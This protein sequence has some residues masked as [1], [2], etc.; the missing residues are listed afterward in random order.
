[1]RALLFLR[2]LLRD[3]WVRGTSL[4]LHLE[5]RWFFFEPWKAM[6]A[7]TVDLVSRTHSS[8][9]IVVPPMSEAWLQEHAA[10]FAKHEDDH[11]S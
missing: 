10:D 1:V 5:W 3:H 2:P 9:R 8:R 7:A 11:T 4:E 6:R